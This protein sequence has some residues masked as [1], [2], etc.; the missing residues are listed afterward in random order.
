M[1][2]PVFEEELLSCSASISPPLSFKSG[3]F[4]HHHTSE[5]TNIEVVTT[6]ERTIEIK[7]SS[8]NTSIVNIQLTSSSLITRHS[9]TPPS[10]DLQ[11]TFDKDT[12]TV[13]TT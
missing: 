9:P 12:Y 5:L 3:T 2:S 4:E 13:P 7:P 10:N 11:I 8:S 1:A 6:P